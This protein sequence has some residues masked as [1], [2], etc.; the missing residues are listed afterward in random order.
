MAEKR[1]HASM[2]KELQWTIRK[3]TLENN[4]LQR[5]IEN[6]REKEVMV[7][8]LERQVELLQAATVSSNSTASSPR[9][10]SQQ[11]QHDDQQQEDHSRLKNLEE[12]HMSLHQSYGLLRTQYEQ[13]QRNHQGER[14]QQQHALQENRDMVR[15]LEKQLALA[16]QEKEQ[17]QEEV[18]VH[19]K[20]SLQERESFEMELQ[21]WAD[22]LKEQAMMTNSLKQENFTIRKE[23]DR[24]R[25][26]STPAPASSEEEDHER[27]ADR[28]NRSTDVSS[29][30]SANHVAS[31]SKWKSLRSWLQEFRRDG[32]VS[33]ED[34]HDLMDEIQR[35]C[36]ELRK[37]VDMLQQENTRLSA[38]MGES[39]PVF[40]QNRLSRTP[41]PQQRLA[42]NVSFVT[43]SEGVETGVL[44]QMTMAR[45]LDQLRK[46]LEQL[47]T[48]YDSQ[49][50]INDKIRKLITRAA[51]VGIPSTGDIRLEI[52]DAVRQTLADTATD[53]IASSFSYSDGAAAI[54][55]HIQLIDLY[56]HALHT[57][58]K[59]TLES[60]AL[61]KMDSSRENATSKLPLPS[62]GTLLQSSPGSKGRPSDFDSMDV[63]VQKL[64]EERD[65]WKENTRRLE[66]D[67]WTLQNEMKKTEQ[68][69]Q[70]LRRSQVVLN[71]TG[72]QELL[73]EM[74]SEEKDI[75]QEVLAAE[76]PTV[77]SLAI[78][79]ASQT[80]PARVFPEPTHGIPLLPE[81]RYF[82]FGFCDH[83]KTNMMLNL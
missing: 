4:Q 46:R 1:Q 10:A 49:V 63:S 56:N 42:S 5:Q 16:H 39:H 71:G 54:K 59:L 14:E 2:A 31:E 48:K 3:L 64:A 19:E 83:C 75:H 68:E 45:E 22:A 28:G 8:A 32:V 62:P 41:D 7:L 74:G 72:E 77:P 38:L 20:R 15:Y 30:L 73:E 67:I 21:R 78:V 11:Q 58:S 51:T 69:M 47:H 60:E 26:E 61:K 6:A 81:T 55:N 33:L 66:S 70:E 9:N 80:E 76:P 29:T 50:K 34:P 23:L 65:A 35:T 53:S 82:D 17:L 79:D 12:A 25:R 18:S 44:S 13:L 24:S 27:D 52:P 36:E 40:Q 57:I 37:E 43:L